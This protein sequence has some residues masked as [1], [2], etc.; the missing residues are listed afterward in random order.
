MSD[1]PADIMK[2]ARNRVKDIFAYGEQAAE[3]L[4][5]VNVVARAII[6]EREACAK[7][8]DEVSNRYMSGSSDY[9]FGYADGAEGSAIAIR[10]PRP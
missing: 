6:A 4:G 2:A 10:S 1:I 8:A 9:V 5:T 7:I 3:F